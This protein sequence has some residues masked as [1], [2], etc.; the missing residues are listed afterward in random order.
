MKKFMRKLAVA[1]LIAALGAVGLT[2][3]GNPAEEDVQVSPSAEKQEDTALKTIRIG[4][5]GQD[6]EYIMEIAS[7]AYK[8]G[9]LE[10]ELN[11]VG[12]TAEFSAFLQTGPEV[13]E[14]LASGSLDAAFYGDF[15]AFLSKSNGID[16]TIVALINA[17]AQYGI[18]TTSEDIK[19]GKDLEGKKVIVSQGTVSQY[20]WE[21][22][23]AAKDIDL[24][25]VEIINSADGAS[26]LQTGE[27]DAYV[28]ML[29]VAKYMESLGLG[30]VFT[31]GANIKNGSTTGVVT[32]ANSFLAENPEVAVALNKALI[33]AYK[34]AAANPEEFY[35][36]IATQQMSK[37]IMKTAYVF[38]ESLSYLSPEITDETVEYYEYLNDWMYEHKIISQKVD[39]ESFVDTSY[40]QTAVSELEEN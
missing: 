34:D 29:Y 33:R 36:A 6:D 32:V 40:Y 31:D 10:E 8:K 7:L 5:G 21:Q 22:Y 23:A 24:D 13:N 30:T 16:T 1:V 12:Y 37:D 38:D 26:L 15:P 19:D 11:A 20:F 18:I 28:C 17:K 14:A 25:K 9:Y 39:V 27:A 4:C 2:G 3:C 35:E